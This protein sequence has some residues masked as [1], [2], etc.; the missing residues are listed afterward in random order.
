MKNL[1]VKNIIEFRAKSEKS[2]KRFAADL[3][4][5]VEKVKA[6]GGG[7]YWIS[8]VSAISN[9]YKKYDSQIIKDKIYEIENKLESTEHKHTKIQFKRNIDLLYK[10]EDFDFKRWQPSKKIT[11][12]RKQNANLLI[13]VKG[14]QIQVKPHHVF[15]FKKNDSEEVGAIWFIAKLGGFKKEELGIYTDLLYRYLKANFSKDYTLNP[16]YCLAI[17]VANCSSVNYSQIESAEVHAIL[18]ATLDEINKLS[19]SPD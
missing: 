19:K 9:T 10:Y 3:K 6:E 13:T 16:K 11:I 15:S 12:V 8:S 7:D 18:I 14:L 5:D 1:S 17:D 4:I 2:K